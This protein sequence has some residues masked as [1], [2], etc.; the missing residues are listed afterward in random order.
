[1]SDQI[2]DELQ[3]IIVKGPSAYEINKSHD[4]KFDFDLHTLIYDL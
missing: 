1:M 4:F 3:H 2:N